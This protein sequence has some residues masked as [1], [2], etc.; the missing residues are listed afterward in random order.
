MKAFTCHLL[1]P[2]LSMVGLMLGMFK[3][4]IAR[5]AVVAEKPVPYRG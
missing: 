2:P 4:V 1:M 3:A 5:V